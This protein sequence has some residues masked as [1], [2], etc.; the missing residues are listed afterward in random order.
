MCTEFPVLNSRG[1]SLLV[2]NIRERESVKLYKISTEFCFE[3]AAAH[4]LARTLRSAIRECL[5]RCRRRN[6]LA[7]SRRK[8]SCRTR[9]GS[10][11]IKPRVKNP[12]SSPGV[13]GMP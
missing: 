4:V 1:C 5:R 8:N 6:L 10:R 12:V 13:L 2:S 11:K 7:E 9:K 3:L